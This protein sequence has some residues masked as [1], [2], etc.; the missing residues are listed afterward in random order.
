MLEKKT[1]F[2]KYPSHFHFHLK[3]AQNPGSP[4]CK[5]LYWLAVLNLKE[6]CYYCKWVGEELEEIYAD[7]K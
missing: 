1:N 6:K 2:P 4:N 3:M 7:P 5:T